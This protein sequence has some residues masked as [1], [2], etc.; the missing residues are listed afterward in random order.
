[1]LRR[2]ARPPQRDRLATAA[3]LRSFQWALDQLDE[4]WDVVAKL[5]AD[6]ELTPQ[7]DQDPRTLPRRTSRH[8]ADLPGHPPRR[9]QVDQEP[10]RA[11]A[12]AGLKIHFEDRFP[13]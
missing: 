11:A 12:R 8:Q 6:I 7:S 3:E 2:P 5:D 10:G 4:E 9:S 1:L 13:G